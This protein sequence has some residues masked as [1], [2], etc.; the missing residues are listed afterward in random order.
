[1][2]GKDQPGFG[3]FGDCGADHASCAF[4]TISPERL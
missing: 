4:G 1:M 3:L 2:N